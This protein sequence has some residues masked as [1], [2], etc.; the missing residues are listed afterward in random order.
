MVLIYS[1]QKSNRLDYICRQ[2]FR[3]IMGFDY[4]ITD[5]VDDLQSF[6]GASI[7]YSTSYKG[8]GIHMAPCGLLFEK[9][10]SPQSPIV[11]EWQGMPVFFQTE[12]SDVPFDLFSASFYLIS[13]YEEYLDEDTDKHGRYKAENSIAYKY[14]FLERPVVD[15]W[16]V[17]LRNLLQDRYD[18]VPE[19]APSFMYIPTVDVD[20]AFAFRHKGPI[21]NGVKILKALKSGDFRMAGYI[22][23][24]LLRLKRDP[25]FNF[26]KLR[27]LHSPVGS[28]ATIFFHCGGRGRYDKR[29]FVPSL[30]Y[31]FAKRKLSRSM[32]AGLHPSYQAATMQKLFALEKWVMERAVCKTVTNCRYH[33]LKFTIP[34]SY[35]M[36]AHEGFT[37]DWS[38]IYSNDP[39]FRAGT[40]FPFHFYNLQND[41]VYKLM[42][43]PTAVMDKTLMSNK[44]MS[45]V[46]AY[47]FI[48]SLSERVRAVN[49]V[50]VTLFHNDHL[51][52]A[53][54]EW[55][56]WKAIY[57][58]MIHHFCN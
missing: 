34:D 14:G 17:A 43:H 31:F 19:F 2:L 20:H 26:D 42:I 10:I 11:S 38:M 3:H 49:G 45:A 48:V 5:N 29:T 27:K 8:V 55:R 23:R 46:E 53:F 13:R 16:A 18:V 41:K 9:S 24:V 47:D 7:C 33:Y 21:V 58:R 35:V 39:G 44:G 51:T 40:S 6:D 56:G 36:L 25:F 54:E 28:E 30:R 12:G 22:M 52:D 50:F 32:R 37:D 4:R 57:G 1:D 15:E